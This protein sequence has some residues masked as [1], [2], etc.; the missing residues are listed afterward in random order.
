MHILQKDATK[1]REEE[2]KKKEKRQS[3]ERL[4]EITKYCTL[5]NDMA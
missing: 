2:E 4:L 3:T 1:K 5:T